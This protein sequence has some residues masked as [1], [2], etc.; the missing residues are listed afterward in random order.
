MTHAS[1]YDEEKALELESLVP[2]TLSFSDLNFSVPNRATPIIQGISG[3]LVSGE[4]TA[5]LGPSGAGKSTFLDVLCRR[6]NTTGSVSTPSPSHTADYSDLESISRR[7]GHELTQC[8]TCIDFAQRIRRLGSY[9]CD[10][11]RRAR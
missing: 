1:S 9:R 7:S 2:L 8:E 4:L 5:I 11:F 6:V 3:T 10:L